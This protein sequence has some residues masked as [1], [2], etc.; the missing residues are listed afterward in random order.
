LRQF[1]TVKFVRLLPIAKN[2]VHRFSFVQYVSSAAWEAH[3][4]AA[5]I[6]FLAA[7]LYGAST[8]SLKRTLTVTKQGLSWA[9]R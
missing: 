6:G 5:A 4:L 9:P 8:T 3:N 2:E 7:R 1:G